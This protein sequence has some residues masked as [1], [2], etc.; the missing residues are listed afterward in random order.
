MLRRLVQQAQAQLSEARERRALDAQSFAR[1]RLEERSIGLL[2]PL[3]SS[4]S[5]TEFVLGAGYGSPC[6]DDVLATATG[7]TSL[8]LLEIPTPLRLLRMQS[9]RQRLEGLEELR[10]ATVEVVPQPGEEGAG[11]ENK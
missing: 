4:S 7:A 2:T 11:K 3:T 1:V 9:A 5:D 8:E 10:E 6:N